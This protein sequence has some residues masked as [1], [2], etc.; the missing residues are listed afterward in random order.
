[1][2]V[3]DN[4]R[5]VSII[6]KVILT[7][8]FVC[9]VFIKSNKFNNEYSDP[10]FYIFIISILFLIVLKLLFEKKIKQLSYSFFSPLQLQLFFLV[11]SFEALFCLL[12]FLN[13]AESGSDYIH[14]TG[15]FENSAGTISVL[16]LLFPLG[17]HFFTQTKGAIRNIIVAQ[18]TIY[19]LAVFICESRTGIL[20]LIVSSIAFF[21]YGY[22][23][24]RSKLININI[25]LIAIIVTVVLS[26]LLYN[27][28]RDSADG[29]LLV[30]MVSLG[31]IKE[32]PLFGFGFH[33]F[34]ANYMDYQA[35][36]FINHP[37]S[38]YDM[39]ADN[40]QHPFNEY[41]YILVNWGI[42]GLCIAL[43]IM[44]LLIYAIIQRHDDLAPVWIAILAA[45]MILC[46]FS[47]PFHYVSVWFIMF[48]IIAYVLKGF[49]LNN[50]LVSIRVPSVIVCLVAL[51]FV[52]C[53]IRDDMRWKVVEQKSLEGYT[54]SMLKYYEILYTK[55]RHNAMF[56][57]NYAAELNICGLYEES[58]KIINECRHK[59]DDYDVRLMVADNYANLGDTASALYEYQQAA[60]MVPCRF[61]PLYKMMELYDTYGDDERTD[62]LARLIMDKPVKIPSTDIRRIKS[63]AAIHLSLPYN[64]NSQK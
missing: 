41:L 29:R 47:Y 23:S 45:L 62:S 56:L 64:S 54:V 10:R 24:F 59:F 1:M 14:V 38:V 42:I 55:Q 22:P 30:W 25:I 48:Y 7:S 60:A 61:I 49:L 8:V 28:K 40:I 37:D 17:L 16:S 52:L 63:A 21:L 51:Y 33:G 5:L 11:G 50:V 6:V 31:M 46:L 58:L 13:L 35:Q 27:W 34:E 9:L 39:L 15:S 44:M 18:M 20:A 3:T 19:I 57:Y 4:N 2:Q 26:I 36:F 43:I 53:N 12:Q 32:H